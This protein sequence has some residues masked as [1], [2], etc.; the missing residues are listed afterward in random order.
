MRKFSS[1]NY[2]FIEISITSEKNNQSFKNLLIV[3]SKIIL[4][5]FIPK[6]LKCFYNDDKKNISNIN[7][8]S[9]KNHHNSI[10]HDC[11]FVFLN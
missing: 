7:C 5:I 8:S 1:E 3:M 2:V 11:F 9:Q 6:L 4:E 10:I